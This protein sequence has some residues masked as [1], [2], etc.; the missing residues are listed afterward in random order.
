MLR[1][2]DARSI[3]FPDLLRYYNGYQPGR[4]WMELRPLMEIRIENAYYKNGASR[5]G[6]EGFLGTEIARYEVTAHGLSLLSFQSMK[7]RPGNDLPVQ[8]LISHAQMKHRY[9]RLYFEIFFQGED[10]HRSVLL[11]SD[12]VQALHRLSGELTG[13]AEVCGPSS[14]ACTVFPEA[15]SVSVEMKIVVNGQSQNVL[16]GSRLADV[17]KDPHKIE[18]QRLY[19]GRLTP[20]EMNADDP[21]ELKLPLLPGDHVFWK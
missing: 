2:P 12:T 19:A 15:C 13:R 20:V 6:L 18:M 8:Q 1:A 7:N 5:R 3:P 11:G 9:Y 10:S 16:W 4:S 21:G 17:V 14:G